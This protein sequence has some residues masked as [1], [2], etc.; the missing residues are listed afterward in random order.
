MSALATEGALSVT[1]AATAESRAPG[2]QRAALPVAVRR[3]KTAR[4]A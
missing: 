1:G 4:S 2:R 3:G